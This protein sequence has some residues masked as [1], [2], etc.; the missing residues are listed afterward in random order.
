LWFSST[1]GLDS[2]TALE[3][4]RAL[5]LATD[6]LG[7]TSVVSIYQASELLY[8]LFDK[9]AVI[10]SGRLIYFGS[11]QAAKDYFVRMGYEKYERTTTADF[12]VGVTDEGGRKVREG[13]E[14][15][16]PRTVEE[17]VKHWEESE[18]CEELRRDV[19][20]CVAFHP[21]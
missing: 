2:S 16:V 21:L 1:R 6:H 12:L 4:V 19:D 7:L 5:R 13:Y 10:H 3:F 8:A 20:R 14:G 17:M 11:A 15:R 9:V 18:E